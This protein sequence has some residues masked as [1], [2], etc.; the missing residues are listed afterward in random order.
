MESVLGVFKD[1]FGGTRGV[2]RGAIAAGVTWITADA[3]LMARA[4]DVPSALDVLSG[5]GVGPGV[6]A[7][8]AFI[9]MAIRNKRQEDD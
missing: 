1:L 3:A 2:V 8:I 6:L 9:G 7:V 5:L 4:A